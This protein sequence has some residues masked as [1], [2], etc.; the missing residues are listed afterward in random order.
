MVRNFS[1]MMK[2]FSFFRNRRVSSY[3]D[4]PWTNKYFEWI[5]NLEPTTTTRQLD[6][7][8]HSFIQMFK[9]LDFPMLSDQF[10]IKLFEKVK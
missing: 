1:E 7:V 9:N 2:S 10:I 8:A 6:F 4:I 3:M 5:I